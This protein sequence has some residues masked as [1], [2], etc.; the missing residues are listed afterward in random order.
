[1]GP[2][3]HEA[4]PA[5]AAG[6]GCWSSGWHPSQVLPGETSPSAKPASCSVDSLQGVRRRYSGPVASHRPSTSVTGEGIERLCTS[7]EP[8]LLLLTPAGG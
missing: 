4:T 2:L 7:L 6:S 1:M 3:T 5:L 8:P